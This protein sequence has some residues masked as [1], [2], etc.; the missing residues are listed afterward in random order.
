MRVFVQFL[1]QIAKCR[2]VEKLA[3]ELHEAGKVADTCAEANLYTRLTLL[4]KQFPAASIL[5]HKQGVLPPE[6]ASL[7][8]CPELLS[9]AK[10]LLGGKRCFWKTQ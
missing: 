1:S 10:Q 8:S 6:I 3:T 4:E 7:W 5:L 9:A 2:L